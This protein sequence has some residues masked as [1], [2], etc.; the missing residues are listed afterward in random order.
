VF[1]VILLL[2]HSQHNL[3]GINLL[4]DTARIVI[5]A[6]VMPSFNLSQNP[7]TASYYLNKIEN[8]ARANS[9]GFHY[10]PGT[11]RCHYGNCNILA[12]KNNEKK[13]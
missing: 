7:P 3:Y 11:Q 4:P 5:S 12:F 2:V 9:V 1:S 6:P 10:H 13:I 8:G